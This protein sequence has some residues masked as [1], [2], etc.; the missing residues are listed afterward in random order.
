MAKRAS[1]SEQAKPYILV[2]LALAMF[3]NLLLAVY[4]QL[5]KEHNVELIPVELRGKCFEGAEGGA[6]CGAVQTS[7]YATTFGV[8]NPYYGYVGFTSLFILLLTLL[9][10]LKR[11]PH[12]VPGLS[13]VI[14]GG[15]MLGS[16]FS[17]WLLYAQYFKILETCVYCLTVDAIMLVSTGLFVWVACKDINL[18]R[19]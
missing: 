7:E 15:M 5:Q 11:Q 19:L 8:S 14:M 6:G 16:A 18:K 12:W 17:V 13:V 2:L 3:A 1:F 4:I 10:A 9:Y